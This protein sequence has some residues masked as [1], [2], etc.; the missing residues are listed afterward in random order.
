[1]VNQQHDLLLLDYA[2]DMSSEML[3]G[4]DQVTTSDRRTL[5]VDEWHNKCGQVGNRP[6]GTRV[7][8]QIC[9]SSYGSAEN[10][11]SEPGKLMVP[12]D[13]RSPRFFQRLCHS[14]GTLQVPR[15]NWISP[16]S[17]HTAQKS[18]RVSPDS[19]SENNV[20]IRYLIRSKIQGSS[21]LN[22]IRRMLY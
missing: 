5:E 19:P 17:W 20:R 1:M 14:T 9:Y 21:H 6:R 22:N 13:H 2:P 4:R 7:S 16:H 8:T 15:G 11:M 10:R 18:T 12:R 3:R